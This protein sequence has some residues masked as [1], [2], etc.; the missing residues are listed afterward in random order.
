MVFDSK[1]YLIILPHI[2]VHSE[3]LINSP[4]SSVDTYTLCLDNLALFDHPLEFTNHF[5]RTEKHLTHRHDTMYD[6]HATMYDRHDAMYD[7]H[8]TMYDRHDAMYGRHDTMYDGH[9]TMYDRH[10][11]MYDRHDPM[12][13]RRDTMYDRR[14]I[15]YN[16]HDTSFKRSCRHRKKCPTDLLSLKLCNNISF[17]N[18]IFN[19]VFNPKNVK[20]S[21]I[22][23][24]IMFVRCIDYPKNIINTQK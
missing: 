11:T 20:T 12:Y 17:L 22:L 3:I 1:K 6:R 13:D 4:H 21:R 10:D 14:D 5:L 23:D 15:M 19:V 16:G 9:D 8:D 2:I 18:F 24:T 7:R